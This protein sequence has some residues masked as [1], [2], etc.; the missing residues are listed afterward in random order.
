MSHKFRPG[1][2]ILE[3]TGE[4]RTRVLC[5]GKETLIKLLNMALKN[6]KG[7]FDELKKE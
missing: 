3:L 5:A 7:K 2:D 6:G 4:E 1:C